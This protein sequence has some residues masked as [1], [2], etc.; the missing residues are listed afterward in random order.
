ML[1]LSLAHSL[2]RMLSYF[3][4]QQ[5]MLKET[6]IHSNSTLLLL[7]L[8]YTNKISAATCTLDQNFLIF[9]DMIQNIS[10]IGNANP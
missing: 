2:Y 7:A 4:H 10:I 6:Q 8:H 3:R 9:L 1:K 5:Q